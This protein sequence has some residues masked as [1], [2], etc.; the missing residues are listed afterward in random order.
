MSTPRVSIGM[1]VYNA[2]RYL[3]E[4][5]DSLLCEFLFQKFDHIIN[6]IIIRKY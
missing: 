5:I 4:A 3:R 6:L 1:P 2:Q